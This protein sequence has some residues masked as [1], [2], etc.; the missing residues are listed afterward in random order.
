MCFETLK[1]WI[2]EINQFEV[3]IAD[4][5]PRFGTETGKQRPVLI[6]QTNFLNRA[7][8]PSTLIAPITSNVIETSKIL[9]VHFP[10]DVAHLREASDVMLDQI[11]AIDNKRLVKK[12]GEIP[13]E[14][15]S[16]IKENLKIIFN[17]GL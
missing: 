5:N 16:Q 7:S 17:V 14:I 2:M 12:L 10:K 4:L 1:R 8:H 15:T 3:W 6:L 11:R 13:T 9:R